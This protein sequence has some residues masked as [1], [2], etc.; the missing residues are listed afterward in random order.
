M[1]HTTQHATYNTPHGLALQRK[2]AIP[3][4]NKRIPPEVRF[5]AMRC[6]EMRQGATAAEEKRG[7]D[8]EGRGEAGH[9]DGDGV[10][11]QQCGKAWRGGVRR[12]EVRLG[13]GYLWELR[14]LAC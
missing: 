8:Q 13:Y 5:G 14:R 10:E 7:G 1:Q 4:P 12:G 11:Q 9:R 3:V 6:A 2:R